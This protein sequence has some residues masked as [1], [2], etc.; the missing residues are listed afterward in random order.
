MVQINS[1]SVDYISPQSSLGSTYTPKNSLET[2]HIPY[3]FNNNVIKL[4]QL[5]ITMVVGLLYQI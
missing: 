1:S 4:L 5:F 3:S 2:T